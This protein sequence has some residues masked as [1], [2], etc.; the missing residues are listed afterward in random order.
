MDSQVT[1]INNLW[2]RLGGACSWIRSEDAFWLDPRYQAGDV[3]VV[4]RRLRWEVAETQHFGT[5][6]P[7]VAE[8]MDKWI[9]KQA[10]LD[11]E[12]AEKRRRDAYIRGQERGLTK[13]G[14][15][16]RAD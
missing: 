15:A 7:D 3:S 16:T 5:M 6:L 10:K 8:K 14:R 13:G 2:D 9:T 12:R 4:P 1:S 11:R